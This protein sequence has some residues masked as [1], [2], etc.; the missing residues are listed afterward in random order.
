M[1]ANLSIFSFVKM[2]EWLHVRIVRADLVEAKAEKR[3]PLL[4]CR[5]GGLVGSRQKSF[6]FFFS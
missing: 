4:R 5:I 1:L 2:G 3:R 6:V